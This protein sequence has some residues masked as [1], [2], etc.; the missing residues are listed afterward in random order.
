M[1]KVYVVVHHAIN[2]CEDYGIGT[3]V[4]KSYN[5]AKA[6]FDS[7]VSDE[8]R[9]MKDLEDL[10]VEETEDSFCACI[11][12]RYSETHSFVDIRESLVE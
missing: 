7:L 5:D 1:G 6:Y 9:Y 8:M 4:F 10:V 2:E 12:G 3:I 11:D